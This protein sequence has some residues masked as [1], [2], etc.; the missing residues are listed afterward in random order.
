MHPL[1]ELCRLIAILGVP[2]DDGAV[3]LEED[4]CGETLQQFRPKFKAGA[5]QFDN[6]GLGL[7]RLRQRRQHGGRDVSRRLAGIRPAP[8]VNLDAMAG[9]GQ[10][11][12]DQPAHQTGSQHG[13]G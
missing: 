7:D 5:A 10:F 13:N 2:E 11:Q 8:L 12:R 4:R 1:T 9:A 6:Q 3:L